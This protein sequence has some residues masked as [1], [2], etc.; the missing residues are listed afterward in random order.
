MMESHVTIIEPSSNLSTSSADQ[1]ELLISLRPSSWSGPVLLAAFLGYVALCSLSRFWRINSMQSRYGFHDRT[2]LGRM[3]NQQ[4]QEI[5]KSIAQLEFPL[6]YDLSIRLALFET[7]AVKNIAKLLV[8]ASDLNIREKAPK[9]YAD[10]EIVYCCFAA[11]SPTSTSLHKAVARM[12]YL[13]APYIKSGKILQEDLLYV[14]YA[15]M[16]EPVRFLAQ[17]EWRKLTDMEVAALATMWKYVGDMMEIDYKT[18]LQKEEWV[19][20][21]EFFEDVSRWG[22][23]YEDENLR[24]LQ[25]VRD[26]GQVLMDLLLQSHPK[27][28]SPLA[29]PAACV[30]MGPRL[31]RAFGFP[32]PGLGITVLTYSLLLVR[33]LA[34]DE[35]TGRITSSHYMK[36]PWYVPSTFWTRWGPEALVTRLAGN[37]LPG[38]GSVDMKPGGLLFEDLGPARFVG[39]GV[40]DTRKM[41]EAVREKASAGCPFN[42]S[43]QA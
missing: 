43:G 24:P 29:H 37:L 13:H 35:Q 16:A 25:E 15:S 5:V 28:A 7:Y 23:N 42:T 2:S 12:N 19:D 6:F 1:P 3:T 4:A 36:E 21:L 10:T 30:L 20:G 33:K 9:R 11:Y 39:K 17:Y 8:A 22:E 18:L 40:E 31:R 27:I 34:P 38:D 41:E 14:L 32:E 26:L